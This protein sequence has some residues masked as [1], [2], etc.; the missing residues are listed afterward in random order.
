LQVDPLE[1]VWDRF[2]IDQVITNLL[3]NAVK[4]GEC[5]PIAISAHAVGLEAIVTVHDSWATQGEGR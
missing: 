1:G 2:R 3:S 5:K 4:F